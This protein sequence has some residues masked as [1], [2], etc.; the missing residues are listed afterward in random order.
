M[1]QGKYCFWERANIWEYFPLHLM[2]KSLS[3]VLQT[4]KALADSES[5]CLRSHV[6][7]YHQLYLKEKRGV[8]KLVLRTHQKSLKLKNILRVAW[9]DLVPSSLKAF[10]NICVCFALR[11]QVHFD[12]CRNQSY[13]G[14][15]FRGMETIFLFHMSSE[16]LFWHHGS[17]EGHWA[18]LEK[19]FRIGRYY[20]KQI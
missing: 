17:L 18:R 7:P 16:W 8:W 10:S 3:M 2:W 11:H 1:I 19:D 20:K 5:R 12:H 4:L 14:N 9:G 6:P 13:K 15:Q